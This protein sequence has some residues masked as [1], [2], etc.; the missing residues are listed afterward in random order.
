MLKKFDGKAPE[1]IDG[2]SK[3]PLAT[4]KWPL[5]RMSQRFE[6]QILE[7]INTFGFELDIYRSDEYAYMY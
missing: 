7:L 1:S 5:W 6:W 3:D 2:V 4:L